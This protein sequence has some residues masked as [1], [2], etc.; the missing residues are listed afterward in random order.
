MNDDLTFAIESPLGDDLTILF[1]RHTAEMH[2]ETPPESIHM[3][4]RGDLAAPDIVFF[5]LRQAGKAVGMAA[6]KHL[7]GHHA[8]VKSMHVLSEMRGAGLSRL[9]L[10]R[11]IAHARGTGL[12]RL[13]LE[14][15]VQ[16]GF[17]AARSLYRR[18]GFRDCPAFGGY[19]PDPNS[20]FMTRDV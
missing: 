10:D 13:S 5:A 20:V 8:E 7:D 16:P 11:L 3:L 4:P 14:T 18:M 12:T 9:M 1:Q 15:G 17:A 6:L 19:R 2:A